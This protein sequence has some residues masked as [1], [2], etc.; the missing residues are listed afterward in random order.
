MSEK[1]I[2]KLNLGCGEDKKAAYVNID[3]QQECKPDVV[4]DLNSIPYPFPANSFDEI[5][6]S[7]VIEHL[8]RPF[9]IMKELHRIL[10]PNGL[11]HIRVPHHSRGF[12]HAE[13]CH[14]FDVTFPLYFN[15]S[16]TRS[17]Y[18]GVHF[19]L[20]EMRLHWLRFFDLLKYYSYSEA[21]I[22]FLKGVNK[23]VSCIANLAPNFCSRI[24]C[25]WVGG[26]DE[27]EFKF[28]C[29]K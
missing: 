6:A 23:V 2:V 28:L 7:H 21:T 15:P 18:Y 3:W 5:L 25:F 29:K 4:H 12:T 19:Q 22:M 14:G 16:F 1:K 13:H 24:W 20:I 9:E 10:R 27:I 26:F 11:L 8:D 17:G